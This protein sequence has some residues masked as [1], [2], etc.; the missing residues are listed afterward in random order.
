MALFLTHNEP[1]EITNFQRISPGAVGGVGDVNMLPRLRTSCAAMLP[2][3]F[4]PTALV[5]EPIAGSNVQDGQVKS[6]DSNGG[7][8]RLYDTVWSGR[9][10]RKAVGARFQDLRAPDKAIEPIV[11][12]SNQ[13]SYKNMVAT[14]VN[15]RATGNKFLPL[16][17]EY[18]ATELTRGGLFPR[19]TDIGGDGIVAGGNRSDGIKRPTMPEGPKQPD[20]PQVPQPPSKIPDSRPVELRGCREPFGKCKGR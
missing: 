15:A 9:R 11:V 16:P 13:Y 10:K 19:I 2:V 17:G 7:P 14:V 12:G 1:P 18:I 4:D 20:L 8:A 6:Y 3:R 5:Q